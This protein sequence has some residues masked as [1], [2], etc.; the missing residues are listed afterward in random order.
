[1]NGAWDDKILELFRIGF[2]QAKIAEIMELNLTY[3]QRRKNVL[4]L[5]EKI[6]KEAIEEAKKNFKNTANERRKMISEMREDVQLDTVNTHI[7]YTKANMK[8]GEA[9]GNDIGILSS[10]I[11]RTPELIVD[12]NINFVITYYTRG[13]EP[14]N[15]LDFIENCLINVGN[16]KGI[17]DK[18]ERARDEINTYIA[19]ERVREGIKAISTPEKVS[20][21]RSAIG[22]MISLDKKLN[23]K[24]FET[25]MKYAVAQ[26]YLGQL[27]K[28]D[29]ELLKE[30][31][32]ISPELI[33][34]NNVRFVVDYLVAGNQGEVAYRFA[35]ECRTTIGN[36]A[37]QRRFMTEIQEELRIYRQRNS[38][39]EEFRRRL[40][41]S[42]E[43]GVMQFANKTKAKTR[44]K[45]EKVAT[46]HGAR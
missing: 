38:K 37:E 15:V 13:N 29:F 44:K 12:S 1:M 40:A 14:H 5:K 31:I 16:N 33:E 21:R 4:I 9:V 43:E 35:N 24:T 42:V 17:T 39:E 25:H 19:K 3:V 22:K 23:K 7:E 10:V 27:D 18:L 45:P 41:V 8:L 11:Q 36:D 28:T 2:S 6:K 32:Q 26:L 34:E 46:G 30:L 20:S